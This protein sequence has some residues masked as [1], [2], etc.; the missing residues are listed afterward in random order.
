MALI[1]RNSLPRPLTH[2]EL[3]S[4]FLYLNIIEW[5]KKSYQ[6]GQYVIHAIGDTKSLYYC[7]K[8]HTDFVYTNNGDDFTET[9][10]QGGQTIRIWTKIGD[11]ETVK[12]VDGSYSG[13]ILHLENSDGST[14]DIPLNITGGGGAVTGGTLNISNELIL[15]SSDGTTVTIDLS[16]LKD[17]Y[18]AISLPNIPGTICTGGTGTPAEVYA[19]KDGNTFQ[20]RGI[21]ALDDNITVTYD[22]CYIYIGGKTLQPVGSNITVVD[23]LCN[24]E[25]NGQITVYVTGGSESYRFSIDGGSTWTAFD[26]NNTQVYTGL[27]AGVYNLKVEDEIIGNII[28]TNVTVGEPAI[29]S[30]NTNVTNVS[31]VGQ[32]DGVIQV[33]ASGGNGVYE[34]SFD[35]GAT[36]SNSDTLTGASE[37]N[38][39][40]IVRD[41][42]GC[43]S[44]VQTVSVGHYN[45]QITITSV[46]HTDPTCPGATGTITINAANGSGEYEF[47]IDGV[48][49]YPTSAP[50]TTNHRTFSTG[51][52]AGT[53][54]N[55]KVRDHNT[56]DTVTYGSTITITDPVGIT[57][58]TKTETNALCGGN[59]T[60]YVKVTNTNGQ[61]Q[62]SLDGSSYTNMTLVS[63]GV[64][65]YTYT[66]NTVG[67]H[68]GTIYYKDTCNQVDSI[69]YSVSKYNAV[70][71]S[72][73]GSTP[74]TC[75]GDDWAHTFS[76]TGGQGTYE[77]SLDNSTWSSFSSPATLPITSST[78]GS[79]STKTVYFRDA[80][81]PSCS[82]SINV[83]NSKVT[84]IN[85]TLVSSSNPSCSTGTGSLSVSASGGRVD[86]SNTYEYAL[87]TGGSTGSYG[88][89]TSFT[90]LSS[91]TYNVAVRRVGTSC[92]PENLASDVT[93]TVPT[94]VGAS[95][96]S[97][98]NPT[99]CAGNNG[100][101]VV[102]VSGGTGT[103]Y[104]STNNGTSYNGSPITPTGGKITISSLSAGSY[105]IKIKDAN[106]CVMIGSG[107][108]VTLSAPSSPSL[109]GTYTAPLCNGGN[110]TIT[111]VA[112][113]G[114]APY[115]YSSNGSSYGSSNVF[116][117]SAYTGNQTYYVK[118]ASNCVTSASIAGS[119]QPS[120][121]SL[122]SSRVDET[123]P[124]ANDGILT[125]SFAGGTSPYTLSIDDSSSNPIPGS[126]FSSATT[127]TPYTGLAPDTYTITLTDANGCSTSITKDI[128]AAAAV[129]TL[130]YFRANFDGTAFPPNQYI[131]ANGINP[132]SAYDLTQSGSAF[133]D[134]GYNPVSF[135]DVLSEYVA[136]NTTYGGGSVNL[137]SA[138]P[139]GWSSSSP[140]SVPFGTV[141]WDS[142]LHIM[143][144]DVVTYTSLTTGTHLVDAANIPFNAY[145]VYATSVT[146]GGQ[147]YKLYSVYSI[148][149]LG[150]SNTTITIK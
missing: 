146:Y 24:G 95:L 90:G 103:Y 109:G 35:G 136:N 61:A 52:V 68:S 127:G 49:F 16:Q 148:V 53:Y 129:Y 10:V 105:T 118:D 42:N 110:A 111:L 101:V 79:A 141:S 145:N 40:V 28:N 149:K 85:V 26:P 133:V 11:G 89:S 114:T 8:S 76:V 41:S 13:G 66:F 100:N 57:L 67:V 70:A 122:A 139:S 96:D 72:L 150:S 73:M 44:S 134:Q 23:N 29:V 15:N 60:V 98:T 80:S 47:S 21:K 138:A 84:T 32:S 38:Y 5:E 55:I 78:S 39:S 74:A 130:Y 120:A 115:T 121:L 102:N 140:V 27:T 7:E 75:P 97:Q 91:G 59:A 45:I 69:S 77:Y 19:G 33:N 43:L 147:N 1:L 31:V 132:I 58:D 117:R 34:Y 48:N 137:S 22:D 112:S 56:L 46:S 123:A 104:Y 6:Q 143:V 64:Y 36:Y 3:D 131:E 25:A 50:F 12:L 107:I 20:F 81:N 30:F 106:N 113:G 37:T 126:P 142:G 128:S 54:S 99:T 125:P 63:S 92:T 88:S 144:P 87:I 124:G 86:I 119:G 93:I 51:I 71:V 2:D 18:D 62:I 17:T 94:A 4:N 9:Y 116:T 14:V 65:Q 82:T 83:N 108:P 135:N